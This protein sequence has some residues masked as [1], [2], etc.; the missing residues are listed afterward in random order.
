MI[1][2][3][4]PKTMKS[5]AEALYGEGPLL[6]RIETSNFPLSFQTLETLRLPFTANG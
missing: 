1:V 3:G 4:I 5:R 6:R 2:R